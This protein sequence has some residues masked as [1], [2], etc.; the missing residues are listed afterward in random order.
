MVPVIMVYFTSI[1]DTGVNHLMDLVMQMV[2]ISIVTVSD[3]YY[4][5]NGSFHLILN[6][7]FVELV[8]DDITNSAICAQK[9]YIQSKKG[10][11]P[12]IGWLAKCQRRR[13]PDLSNCF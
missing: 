3:S 5:F 8:D 9:I 1:H 12:W 10:F 11:R 7:L 6:K 4:S 13:L 2:V